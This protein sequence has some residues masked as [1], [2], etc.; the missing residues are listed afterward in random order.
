M[1]R[2]R[3][4][5]LHSPEYWDQKSAEK[6]LR[7]VF[8]ICHG[9][10]RCFN[11]CALFPK[12]FQ[13]LDEPD[14]DGDVEKLTSGDIAAL[15]P[16]CTLCDMCYMVKC[17]YVPPHPWNVDFPR[18]ILRYKAIMSKKNAGSLKNIITKRLARVDQYLPM[19]N[20]CSTLGNRVMKIPVLRTVV[21]KTTGV[22]R[23][24]DMPQFRSK[25]LKKIWLSPEPN[26]QGHAFGQ[27]A[28]LFLTC[29]HNY[30]SSQTAEA[31][32]R[33]LAHFGVRV[34]GVYPGCCGMPLFE[35]GLVTDVAKQAQKLAPYLKQFSPLI[36]ITP[37]CTLM[38]QSEWPALCPDHGDVKT[39]AEQT[40]DVMVYIKNLLAK[41]PQP[42]SWTLPEKLGV[43]MACHVRAQNKGNVSYDVLNKL[44]ATR[45][46]LIEKCSG[47]GGLWG[48]QTQNYDDAMAMATGVVQEGWSLAVITSECPMAAKHLLQKAKE[49]GKSNVWIVHP[50]VLLASVIDS[51]FAAPALSADLPLSS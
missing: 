33:L 16:S 43:H 4:I 8:D 42:L 2:E 1:T 28:W 10:R 34:H 12:L 45:P 15:I 9:C 46:Q 11:L 14:I 44:S 21:E 5:P 41:A 35:Q 22:D 48:Y 20:T 3:S 36:T 51:S 50:L 32:A 24:V 26:P 27:E 31:A 30:Y 29:L 25:S 18:A 23:R 7:R 47:H 37:S 17:P 19:A 13:R 39:V 6:E 40:V 49:Q 38:I